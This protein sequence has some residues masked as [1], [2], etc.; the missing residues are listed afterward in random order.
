[1][2]IIKKGGLLL[3]HFYGALLVC[4]QMEK[5]NQCIQCTGKKHTFERRLKLQFTFSGCFKKYLSVFAKAGMLF[6]VD[7]FLNCMPAIWPLHLWS[8][9]SSYQ[10]CFANNKLLFLLTCPVIFKAVEKV[11]DHHDQGMQ[12]DQGNV[13]LKNTPAPTL[14]VCF[15]WFQIAIMK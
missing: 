3:W 9:G 8:L 6:P 1:M 5:N 4:N 2:S 11:K 15:C 14:D 13:H 12:R 7:N 10:S